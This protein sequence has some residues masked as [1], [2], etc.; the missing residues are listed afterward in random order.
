MQMRKK[1]GYIDNT[2]KRSLKLVLIFVVTLFSFQAQAVI[3]NSLDIEYGAGLTLRFDFGGIERDLGAILSEAAVTDIA[4]VEY[5]EPFG[6]TF[7]DLYKPNYDDSWSFK[8]GSTDVV[9]IQFLL[10]GDLA[11]GPG[12]NCTETAY[13]DENAWD[14]W[15]TFIGCGFGGGEEGGDSTS[16][17]WDIDVG[18]PVPEPTAA[19]LFGF[20]TLMVGGALRRRKN[21]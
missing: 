15:T 21:A 8:V 1:Q 9:D 11:V 16:I 14:P 13:I 17:A 19:L 18:A 7:D 20:G 10:E 12:L 4:W 3:V 6:I 5:T 2:F